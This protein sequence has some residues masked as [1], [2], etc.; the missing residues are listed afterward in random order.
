MEREG[1]GEGEREG[2]ERAGQIMD[3]IKRRDLYLFVK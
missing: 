3:R 1:L 2:L